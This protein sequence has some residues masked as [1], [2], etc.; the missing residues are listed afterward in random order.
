MQ[1]LHGSQRARSQSE[2]WRQNN[3]VILKVNNYFAISNATAF[4]SF[5]T[6]IQKS[7]NLVLSKNYRTAALSKEQRA[8]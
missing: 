7:V 8:A 4:Y 6:E 2:C 1:A 5:N 3:T